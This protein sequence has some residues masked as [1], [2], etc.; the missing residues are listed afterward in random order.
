[1][2]KMAKMAVEYFTLTDFNSSVASTVVRLSPGNKLPISFLTDKFNLRT[3]KE[4]VDGVAVGIP[5]DANGVSFNEYTPNSTIQ[6]T[7]EPKGIVQLFS[8]ISNSFS[9]S[10]CSTTIK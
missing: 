6:I 8:L 1:M 4:I 7:G 5:S 10:C 9:P 2:A 3:V